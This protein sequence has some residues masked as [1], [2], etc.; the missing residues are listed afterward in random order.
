M[1]V[2]GTPP[3]PFSAELSSWWC[4]E[5]E[6]RLLLRLWVERPSPYDEE[7]D[8]WGGVHDRLREVWSAH[9]LAWFEEDS[10]VAMGEE[11]SRYPK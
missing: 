1:A 3:R 4:E 5:R 2:R 10:L 7:A 11:S 9:L 6:D 8:E